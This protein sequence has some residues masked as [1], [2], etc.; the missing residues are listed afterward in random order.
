MEDV[1]QSQQRGVG[2]TE[3]VSELM[4]IVTLALMASTWLAWRQGDGFLIVNHIAA[5]G[6]TFLTLALVA[7]A[8][9]GDSSSGGHGW[10][11]NDLGLLRGGFISLG[12]A[13]WLIANVAVIVVFAGIWIIN[14]AIAKQSFQLSISE[15][16][17]VFLVVI[18]SSYT[19]IR[20]S[21][22]S[23]QVTLYHLLKKLRGGKK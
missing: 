4:Q 6:M 2:K 3:H 11:D 18:V 13:M 12:L 16:W 1:K 22:A 14:P 23:M 8:L 10:Y 20:L 19:L 5:V 17:W 9:D 21:L 15:Q 7:S